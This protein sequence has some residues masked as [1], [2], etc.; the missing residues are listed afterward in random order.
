MEID[1]KKEVREMKDEV[2]EFRRALHQQP[3]LSLHE[4]MTTEYIREHLEEWG[5]S[6]RP[7]EPSGI[8]AVIGGGRKTIVLRADI[9]ALEIEEETGL[10][11]SSLNPESMHACAHDGHTAVLLAA[12]RILKKNEHMLDRKIILVFQPAEEIAQ[13]AKLVLDTGILSGADAIFGLHIFSGIEAGKISLEPG[14]R[15]AATNWF[16]IRIKGRSGHAGK[17]HE[18][19]DS[20]VVASSLV[21]NL[22]TVVSRSINPLENAVLTIGK[23]EA[24]TARNV[25]AGE[26]LLEGTVRTFSKGAEEEIGEKIRNIA[27]AVGKMYDADIFVD[28]Q[29]SS[30]PALIND[31]S[32][33]RDVMKKAARVFEADEFIH[34]PAMMLGEDFS[35]YLEEIP[36]CFA[37]IGGGGVYPNH[38]SKFDF[39]ESALVQGVKMMLTFALV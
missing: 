37:F 3:E 26:A 21:M 10:D 27:E 36:G 14:P 1:I 31:E 29:P 15:M 19:V 12:A 32:V 13:G 18:C 23:L 9:D 24:G 16:S 30:H 7:L 20:V 2:V 33:V 22:Q 28:Y 8:L 11:F 5:I 39:D 35:N 25:V 38:H 17:P 4:T 6:Y 34:V